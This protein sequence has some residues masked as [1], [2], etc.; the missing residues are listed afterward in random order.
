MRNKCWQ[1]AKQPI[2]QSGCKIVIHSRRFRVGAYYRNRY[3]TQENLH[4]HL[5][6]VFFWRCYLGI[7]G[8]CYWFP[9]VHHPRTYFIIMTFSCLELTA[10]Q[11]KFSL[12]LFAH[13][14]WHTRFLTQIGRWDYVELWINIT[15]T[16][17]RW[18]EMQSG[19]WTNMPRMKLEL[20]WMELEI[21]EKYIFL[22][23]KN[24]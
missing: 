15:E 18:N 21:K 10:K 7:I 11:T 24:K 19:K 9:S 4:H 17:C 6:H 2:Q 14:R 3:F 13:I 23:F 8:N 1:D 5:P 12:N 22:Q 20:F 16:T